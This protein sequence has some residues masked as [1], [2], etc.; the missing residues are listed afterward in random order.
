[1]T[2]SFSKS[3]QLIE[4]IKDWPTKPGVYIMRDSS[5]RV[6]YVGKAKN[7]KKRISSYF[8]NP[9]NLDVK[10][11]ILV[12]KINSIE[13]S[14]TLNELEA[15]LLENTLI[16]KHQPRYN[17]RLKDDK[18]Y[19]YLVFNLKHKFPNF[20]V[21]RRVDSSP[22]LR[23]FGPY[24]SGVKELTRFIEKT[25]QIRDCG[26]S[27]FSN[28]QRPCLNYEIKLCTGP[29][30]GLINENEYNKRVHEA[31][32]FL[33][34][35]KEKL[36]TRLKNQMKEASK[37]FK[38]EIAKEFRDKIN[39]INEVFQKQNVVLF[40]CKKDIDIITYLK[41]NDEIIFVVLF[42]RSGNLVGKKNI[43][44][45]N[46]TG[47]SSEIV[48]TFIS[49]FY[50]GSIFPPDEIWIE[51]KIR[52]INLEKLI[53]AI[54]GKKVKIK[55][56]NTAKNLF[57]IAKENAKAYQ[58]EKHVKS[59]SE[60]LKDMLFLSEKPEIITAIDVSNL[61]ERAPVVGVVVFYDEKPD[62]KMY[63]LY[64]PRL[65]EGQDDTYM[66]YEG[67]LRHFKN[68][69]N[70]SDLLV[71]DGGK[72]QLNSAL[73]ALRELN[74]DIPICAIAKSRTERDFYSPI[75]EK[76][77]ERIFVPFQK[78]PI[79]PK[80]N[81]PGL[82]LI[83]MIRNEAHRFALRGHRIRRNAEMDSWLT[84]IPGIGEK[85][86]IKILKAFDSPDSLKK[87]SYDDLIKAGL[88]SK[89]AKSLLKKIDL[90]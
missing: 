54:H 71:V 76:T 11:A 15:L 68:T 8:R 88:N 31:F 49:Q 52:K 70:I 19:P 62:K 82:K 27:K 64:H 38:F 2:E 22:N 47:S 35:K 56:P 48:E 79:I 16:K 7:L 32:L 28:R 46:A 45:S 73:R 61:E 60:D 53:F 81:R 20:Y 10:T 75:I 1:M 12:K 34:G 87:A 39:T 33:S 83:Q 5:N 84:D 17:M 69:D 59:M 25:F 42:I 9:S 66:I 21:T 85:N 24:N 13:F 23:Y 14:I 50:S 90:L 57:A 3:Q 63:R 72:A 26:N 44:T 41:T 30:V 18:N 55:I 51:E 37:L 40:K 29:C 36:I 78:N 43:R 58:E 86:R 6:I 77:E 89:A 65:S 4:E 67:V 80:E 74:V